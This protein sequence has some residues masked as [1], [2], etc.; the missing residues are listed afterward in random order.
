MSKGAWRETH[1]SVAVAT[2]A[3]TTTVTTTAE[4]TVTTTT[5]SHHLLEPGVNVLLGFLEDTHKIAG[6]LG[7]WGI[8]SVKEVDEGEE[9]GGLTISCE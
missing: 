1:T 8:L 3:A 7:I 6:L 5:V 2:I 9:R 4:T